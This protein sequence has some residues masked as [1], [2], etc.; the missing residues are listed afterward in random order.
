MSKRN[1]RNLIYA[2]SLIMVWSLPI[3][4]FMRPDSPESS[5]LTY[6]LAWEWGD[7]MQTETGW[8]VTN[9][10][11][12]TI[13]VTEGYIVAYEAQLNACEHSHGWFNWDWLTIPSVYAGHGDDSNDSSLRT[14]YVENIALP[15]TTAWGTVNLAEP[16]YCEAF[17]LVA[18]GATDTLNQPESVDMFA[19]SIYLSGTVTAPDNDDAMPFTLQTQHANGTVQPFLQDEQSVHLALSY[20]DMEIAIVRSLDTLFDEIDFANDSSDDAS[21]QVL[22][23]LLNNTQFHV[24]SGT[25]HKN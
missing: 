5:Q 18:R 25:T 2:L 17:F 12:Y 4:A 6:T 3:M 19:T 16:T 23:N 21:F 22:R 15:E 1:Q 13:E 11:G 9:N 10:L 7:A 24:I 20:D 14:S 8:Q